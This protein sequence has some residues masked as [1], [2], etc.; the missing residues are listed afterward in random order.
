MRFWLSISVFCAA[1]VVSSGC[2]GLKKYRDLESDYGATQQ[3]LAD[4]VGQIALMEEEIKDLERARDKAQEELTRANA[5]LEGARAKNAELLQEKGNLTSDVESMKQ[6]MADLEARKA[7]AE[8]RIAAY[9]DLLARFQKLIDAGK[10]K[11]KIVDGRM[12][13][14]LAT[15]VLFSSGSATL[16]EAGK[17]AI[18]EVSAIL[19]SLPDRSYQIEGHTDNV[20]IRTAQYPSNWELAAARALTV[21]KTMVDAGMPSN[22]ISA[23]SFA[24]TRPVG[25]NDAPDGKAANRRIEI[26]V[27]PDLSTL[28]GYSELQKAAG[29]K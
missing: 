24:E 26:V 10:L 6:A 13:V 21:L 17:G 5:A 29:E 3:H 23:A 7:E 2:V 28:P 22:R 1:M 20:P 16:S 19:A 12:V 18:I 11:V 14:E 9:R 15:D 4:R 8:K 25:S 27:V